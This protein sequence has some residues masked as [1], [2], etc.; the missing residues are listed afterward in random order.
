[1]KL[2]LKLRVLF[3]NLN[4]SK[5]KVRNKIGL[6]GILRIDLSSLNQLSG[7]ILNLRGLALVPSRAEIVTLKK[8]QRRIVMLLVGQKKKRNSTIKSKNKNLGSKSVGVLQRIMSKNS[9]LKGTLTIIEFPS[10]LR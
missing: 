1:M 9:I 3:I 10:K 6:I 8:R 4:I 7:L 2:I 5:N